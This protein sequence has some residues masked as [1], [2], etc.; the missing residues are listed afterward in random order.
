MTSNI[1]A[2]LS[3]AQAEDRAQFDRLLFDFPQ[4]KVQ[5]SWGWGESRGLLGWQPLRY[6]LTGRGG[7]LFP[8][9]LQVKTISL[10]KLRLGMIP[11]MPPFVLNRAVSLEQFI[12]ALQTIAKQQRLSVVTLVAPFPLSGYQD[13]AESLLRAGLRR[14]ALVG[15][16]LR[17]VVVD[18]NYDEECL[19]KTMKYGHRRD[20]RKAMRAGVTVHL[21]R[22]KEELEGFYNIYDEM[23]RVKQLAPFPRSFFASL[24]EELAAADRI[25][26]FVVSH[27]SEML[28]GTLV[29]CEPRGYLMLFSAHKRSGPDL[30]AS[31]LLEWEIM[32]DGRRRGLSYYDLG[33]I[34]PDQGDER[35]PDQGVVFWKLGFGGAICDYVGAFDMV[36]N[37]LAY[38]PFRLIQSGKLYRILKAKTRRRWL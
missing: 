28:G 22:E 9:S 12:D 14:S 34:P 13:L 16:A 10:L 4:A 2:K 17:S 3:P 11:A 8:L 18:L 26:L 29:A 33:G 15:P 27:N 5:L 24:W 31:R 32:L 6:L 38:A 20:A 21:A 7:S 37:P 23:C 1:G 35:S 25:R 19:L 30:G 36:A